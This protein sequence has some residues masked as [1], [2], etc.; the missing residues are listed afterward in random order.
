MGAAF[1]RAGFESVDVHMTDMLTGRVNLKDFN[2]IVACGGFSYGDVLGAGAGWAKSVLYNDSLKQMFANFF[3]RKDS[4]ALGVCNGCQMMSQLKG[5]IPGA[6]SWP[7]FT[8]N[9]SEQFEARYVTVE[10]LPTPSIFFKDMEG[11]RVPIPV[12]HGEGFANFDSTGSFDMILKN[13]LAAMRFVDNYGRPTERYPF[14]PNGSTDGLT[15][16]TTTDGRVTIMMPHPERLFRSVQMSYRP[17][18]LFKGEAGPWQ[19][20]FM[21]ARKFVGSC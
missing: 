2:G 14:N 8:K 16:L 12:A 4:F 9:K 17:R 19:K 10:I 18:D 3:A 7:E 20:M 21:N 6:E 5:I 1:N 13:G 11:S 15:A